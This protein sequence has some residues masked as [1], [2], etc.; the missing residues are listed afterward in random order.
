MGTTPKPLGKAMYVASELD[1]SWLQS[2]QRKLYTQSWQEPDYLFRK[3][4]GLV[5]DRH[6]LRTAFARVARNKGRR[7]SGVD[8]ITV[9]K[10]VA[11]GVDGFVEQLRSELRS[12]AFRPSP[13]RRVLI[14]KSGKPTETRPLGIPTVKDRVVQAALKSILEPIFEADFYPSSY[15]FR[16]ATGVWPALEEARKLLLPK[17][18]RRGEETKIRFPYQWAI[19]GDIKGCFD[20]IS[21]HGL[22]KRMRRRIADPKVNRLVVTFLKSGVLS[23]EHFLRTN[24]GTPQGG[25]LSPLLANIALSRIDERYE[26]SVWPRRQVGTRASSKQIRQYAAWNRGND[27]RRGRIVFV[28]IRYADDFII[29][30][31]APIGPDQQERAETAAHEERAALA[32]VL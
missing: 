23:E 17:N 3:L 12:G 14:P 22:M 27:K 6:N 16:P 15:G 13:V 28:P 32:K 9:G 25:I 24:A 26:R 1:Q 10:L 11:Q 30:V 2:M 31:G 29:F 19:E 5:T 4:W 18:V 8:G 21:H 7:T 20:H